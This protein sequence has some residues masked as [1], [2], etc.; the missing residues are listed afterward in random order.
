MF[1]AGCVTGKPVGHGGIR[2]RESATGLGVFYAIRSILSHDSV[3]HKT[4]LATGGI[5]GKT[6][7]VQGFGNVG[8]WTAKFLAEDGGKIIAVAERDGILHDEERG[9]SV[10]AL[11]KHMVNNK[12]SIDGFTNEDSPSFSVTHDQSQFASMDCDVLVP[13]ALESVIHSGNAHLVKAKVIAEAA[14]G[15]ITAEADEILNERGDVVIIPDLLANSMGVMCSYVEWTK[16]MTGMRLGRLTR[17]FEESHGR[18]LANILE[19]NGLKLSDEQKENI[20]VG[21]DEETHV[22]SGLEDTM[23]AA[24][25]EVLRIAE[26]KN[27]SLRDAAYVKSLEAIA[28]TYR[29]AGQWP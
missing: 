1:T 17:R 12:G 10:P 5:K 28:N 8:Y 9:I 23:I 7:L 14:N 20:V 25:A 29:R 13:A 3:L 22:R 24:S 26:E 16:N 21:A 27:C 19:S 2:G 11:H 6:F 4:G 18:H 15:P